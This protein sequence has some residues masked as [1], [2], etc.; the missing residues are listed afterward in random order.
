MAS[1]GGNG[2]ARNAVEKALAVLEVVAS[3]GAPHRLT[4]IASRVDL[5]KS[6]I[7]RI[8]QILGRDDYVV[9]TSE[10]AYF[11]GPKALALAGQMLAN[12]DVRALADPILSELQRATG[13]T[14]HLALRSG[15]AAVYVGK[16]EGDRPYRM[17]SRVG[18]A[19]PLHCTSI[20][21]AILAA[22]PAAETQRLL[23]TTPL[24]ARTP[25]TRTTVAALGDDLVA[26]RT[27]R[28][29][30]DD[31]ENEQSVR[32][33]GAAVTDSLGVV[34]GGI[35]ISALVFDFTMDDAIAAGPRVVAAAGAVSAALGSSRD[36]AASEVPTAGVTISR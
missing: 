12:N 8:L 35:S 16:F 9:G 34:V 30:I 33:V 18:A 6:T 36:G 20:G 21:K 4:E 25:N 1:S 10:G 11:V 28:F 23:E 19:I 32:C 27:R 5:P 29:A 22:L 2:F 17:A 26:I 13:A 15:S 14:V 31:E 3:P 24:V 7:H